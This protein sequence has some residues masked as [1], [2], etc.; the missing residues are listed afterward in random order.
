MDKTSS[1]RQLSTLILSVLLFM[2]SS[3]LLVRAAGQEGVQLECPPGDLVYLGI[4]DP[5]DNASGGPELAG[6]GLRR[7]VQ[8]RWGN[9]DPRGFKRVSESPDE[10]VVQYEELNSTLAIAEIHKIDGRW[11]PLEFRACNSLL[12]RSG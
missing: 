8:E 7:Y 4:P 2:G 1:K 9:L 12:A 3:A 11:F 10:V 5:P 6:E